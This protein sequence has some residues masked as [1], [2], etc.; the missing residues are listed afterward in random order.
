MT[1]MADTSLTSV[2][3]KRS[4][5]LNIGAI[6]LGALTV[7]CAA[8]WFFPV[9][10]ALSTSLKTDDEAVRRGIGLLPEAPTLDGYLYV[11]RNSDL[12]F[13]YLNST[14]T[15]VAVTVIA[16]FMAACAGYAISQLRFPGRTLLWWTILASFMVPV[17]ALIVN[18]FIIMAS[19]KLLNTHLGIILPMLITPVTVIVYKQFF[20]SL[21]REFR[22][23][24]VMD[25]AN[26]F[27]LLFRVFLPMN[28]GITT[29]LAIITFIGAWN[30]FLWPFLAAQNEKMM[31]VT[32][33]ITAVQDTFGVAYARLM[34]GAV[35]AGLPVALAYII[36]QRRVT[37]AITLS[38]GIKG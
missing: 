23:A 19:V 24:A 3:R 4:R 1:A 27:Q 32:V 33:G 11:I 17:Q 29:A 34:A 21:P 15:S 22:E 10:W 5:P 18:H 12:P 7:I 30:S 13:W 16:V 28:W 9:F 20:D 35:L 6:L 8:I 25:G 2:E 38:A 37:Q 36:F 26:E 14:I 31:T